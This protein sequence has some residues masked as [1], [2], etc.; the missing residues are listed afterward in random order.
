MRQCVPDP[1]E[2]G[3]RVLGKI[4][5][6]RPTSTLSPL[7]ALH[8]PV[9]SRGEVGLGSLWPI[10]ALSQ[11]GGG[12]TRWHV[13]FQQIRPSKVADTCDAYFLYTAVHTFEL[14]ARPCSLHCPPLEPSN[15][16][17]KVFEPF[18]LICLGGF[19]DCFATQQWPCPRRPRGLAVPNPS[20]TLSHWA[21]SR[22][23]HGTPATGCAFARL[24]RMDDACWSTQ[25][26]SAFRRRWRKQ[27]EHAM[28]FGGDALDMFR[29]QGQDHAP[30][31]N[32]GATCC[33]HCVDPQFEKE[34]P[35]G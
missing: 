17:F 24:R 25:D 32:T 3:L 13:R 5:A 16:R 34:G 28:G 30:I 31:A 1:A 26:S 9:W 11:S 29:L 21:N 7:H 2:P 35:A 20:Q 19:C 23:A 8:A 4:G 27:A 6:C 12:P 14:V 15:L 18:S 33:F 22:W 10:L